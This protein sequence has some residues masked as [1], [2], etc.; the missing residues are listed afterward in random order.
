MNVSD[1]VVAASGTATVVAGAL[2]TL[3]LWLV[4]Q[5]YGVDVP[6]PVQDALLVLVAAGLTG[7]GTLAAGWLRPERHPAPPPA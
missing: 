2:C 1:K 3:G 5:R 4:Q 6:G 7:L